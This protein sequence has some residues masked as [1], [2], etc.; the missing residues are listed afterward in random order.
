MFSGP[1][2]DALRRV[3]V[4]AYYV[5]SFLLV[6]PV[7]ETILSAWPFQVHQT[8]WRITVVSSVAN[9]STTVL[10]ALLLFFVV[11][12]LLEDRLALLF[13]TSVGIFVTMLCIFGAG[14]FALDALQ[15]RSQV[16]PDLATRYELTSLWGLGR[17]SLAG[18]GTLILATFSFRGGRAM[19]QVREVATGAQIVVAASRGAAESPPT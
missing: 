14:M 6:A 16:R 3:R 17:I 12:T 2:F 13:V 4:P 7:I 11:G 19:D 15:M 1:V 10:L 9:N 18:L 8:L 5:L